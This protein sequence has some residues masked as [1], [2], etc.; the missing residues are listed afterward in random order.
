MQYQ[1]LFTIAAAL[2]SS[3][4]AITTS[5][6][7]QTITDHQTT[8]VTITSCSDNKCDTTV[9]HAVQSVAT[10]TVE[11]I[12]TVYTTY[13]PL[14]SEEKGASSAPAPA[15][16]PASSSLAGQA[17]TLSVV[18]TTVQ[19]V[20][21]IYTTYCPLSSEEEAAPATAATPATPAT[22]AAPDSAATPATPATAAAPDSAATPATP[23]TADTPATPATPATAD[24]PATAATPATPATADT[25]ATAAT[26]ATPATP[27]TAATPA[28]PG[29]LAAESSQSVEQDSY[30]DIT[31][32]PTISTTEGVLATETAQSTLFTSS[33]GSNSTLADVSIY[34]GSAHKI[35]VGFAAVAGIAAALI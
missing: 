9:N 21:T 11:G 29:S 24:T 15:P 7:L 12:E 27:E 8:E 25:P 6:Q 3:S 13:C 16:A 26:S 19:G 31:V 5:T 30:V 2:V 28:N 22:A 1:A 33:I 14:S 10:T 4:Y 20:E 35:A 23:A 18:T 17:S 34:E 32:T